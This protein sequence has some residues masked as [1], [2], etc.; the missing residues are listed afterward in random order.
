ADGRATPIC[1]PERI[2]VRVTGQCRRRA[3]TKLIRALQGERRNAGPMSELRLP[4]EIRRRGLVITGGVSE[5]EGYGLG[6]GPVIASESQ[7]LARN[8]LAYADSFRLIR[9][10]RDLSQHLQE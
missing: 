10:L 9:P 7:E 1:F 2:D 5:D 3:R 8:S 6:I 4:R